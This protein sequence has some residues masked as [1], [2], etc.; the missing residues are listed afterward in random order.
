MNA[1]LAVQEGTVHQNDGELT[2]CHEVRQVSDRSSLIKG[3]FE[4]IAA[5]LLQF[6]DRRRHFAA[7]RPTHHLMTACRH[8]DHANVAHGSYLTI[9]SSHSV[10]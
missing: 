8:R 1:E 10:R 9:S 2:P 6:L 4:R 5:D 3:G 7:R